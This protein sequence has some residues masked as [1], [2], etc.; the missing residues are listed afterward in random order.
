M[1]GKFIIEH[2]EVH[3]ILNNIHCIFEDLINKPGS[4]H[5]SN[6]GTQED[7]HVANVLL[8][9]LERLYTLRA[10]GPGASPKS[11]GVE[12][13]NMQETYNRMKHWQRLLNAVYSDRAQVPD[14]R[15]SK[16]GD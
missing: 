3:H 11:C 16:E 5:G 14:Q 15:P 2:S 8:E 7:L 13:S 12:S 4:G 6:L 9:T 1:S 10:S